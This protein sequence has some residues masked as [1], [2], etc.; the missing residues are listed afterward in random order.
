M[1][2]RLWV[3]LTTMM[4]M[5]TIAVSGESVSAGEPGA[6]NE[7]QSLRQRVTELEKKQ[8]TAES[9]EAGTMDKLSNKISIGGLI[10][11]AYQYESPG[12][13]PECNDLDRG[14]LPIQAELSIKPA[15]ADEIF[16]KVGFAG[17]NGLNTEG[18]AFVL[19]PWAADLEDD[20]KDLNGRNRDYLLTAWYAHTFTFSEGHAL[21]VTGGIIDAT[22]YLDDNAYANCEYTQFMNEALVNGANAFLPSYDIGGAVAWE[23]GK[24]AMR[25]VVMGIGEND[26]GKAY[27]FYGVQAGYTLDTVLG[28]GTY[29]VMVDATSSDF[30]N[31]D[32]NG[33]E[34]LKAM[35]L[36]FDQAIG[37]LVG[38]W[39]RCGWSDDSAIIDFKDLYSGGINI[40]GTLW[41]RDGDNIGLGYAHLSGGNQNID[42][43]QVVEGYVRFALNPVFAVT[44]DAQYLDDRYEK[45]AGQ[46]VDG[47]ITGIRLT[48][49]F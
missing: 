11:G 32:E 25:G 33:K 35:I 43:T 18:H 44:L 7:I 39:I 1:K 3:L 17:G 6:Q 47:W 49:I 29:R 45:G 38:V 14:A 24:L 10:A 28:E 22:D 15:E 36:S 16:F 2:R 42:W 20:V 46:D 21:G 5:M 40:S 8:E 37:E 4:M 12:G 9:R 19:A 23:I 26:E 34:S 13:S 30:S 27:H 41:G 31:P 48:A